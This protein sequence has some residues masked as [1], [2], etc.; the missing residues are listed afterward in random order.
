MPN[1]Q[2]VLTSSGGHYKGR[3]LAVSGCKSPCRHIPRGR[4]CTVFREFVL[5]NGYLYG[6]LQTCN[7]SEKITLLLQCWFSDTT[8]LFGFPLWWNYILSVD[9][10]SVRVDKNVMYW[11]SVVLVI[12]TENTC[13]TDHVPC[14]YVRALTIYPSPVIALMFRFYKIRLG[15][16][17]HILRL[18]CS[19]DYTATFITNE[20]LEALVDDRCLDCWPRLW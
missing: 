17:L 4:H 16:S 7:S 6:A 10:T 8:E 13:D 14:M 15:Q 1:T 20:P 19:E 3:V 5:E 18:T 9:S 12:Y 2:G 11:R